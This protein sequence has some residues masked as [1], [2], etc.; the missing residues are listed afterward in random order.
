MSIPGCRL[1]AHSPIALQAALIL[2]LAGASTP[3]RPAFHLRPWLSGRRGWL[4]PQ[5]RPEPVSAGPVTASTHPPRTDPIRPPVD[6]H[7]HGPIGDPVAEVVQDQ[8][9]RLHEGD[10]R[11]HADR[12]HEGVT[13]RVLKGP[14]VL[15]IQLRRDRRVHDDTP[16]GDDRTGTRRQGVDVTERPGPIDVDGRPYAARPICAGRC[17]NPSMWSTRPYAS[18]S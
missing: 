17:G 7:E 14:R 9:H 2:G 18:A 15:E 8:L 1:F 3:A 16:T 5:P 13:G 10:E 4:R 6:R 11:R 12:V